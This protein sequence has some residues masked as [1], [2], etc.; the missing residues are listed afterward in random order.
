VAGDDRRH[1]RGG[2]DLS[3]P[4]PFALGVLGL[5]AA[6][7]SAGGVSVL[8]GWATRRRIL[9]VPNERSSHTRPTPRGGG[10]AIVAVVLVGTALCALGGLVGMTRALG[11]CG[12]GAL[13]VAAVSWLEDLR[14]RPVALR[15]SVHV[16]AAVLA[17]IGSFGVTRAVSPIEGVSWGAAIVAAISLVWIVGLTNA[18]NFMDGID[19]IAGT[20]GVIAGIAWSVFGL[21]LGDGG[22]A[23][24]GALMC[25]SCLGFLV[26]NWPPA[27]IFMGDVGSAFLGFVLAVLPLLAARSDARM[28]VAGV[29]VVWPFVFDT[30]FTLCRRLMRRENVFHSHRSHL[31]QRLVVAGWRHRGATL[32]YG[33]LSGATVCVLWLWLAGVPG[34][35]YA[36]VGVPVSGAALVL[37]LVSRAEKHSVATG[38]VRVG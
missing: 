11:L 24:I 12:L 17:L 34:A 9:D 19:G 10:L 7:A 28:V 2:G 16:A 3:F 30:G 23:V 37:W 18:Y 31:Y 15:L 29:L 27:R 14:R 38:S 4:N 13:L 33:A 5:G 8:R 20:Q 26:H 36:V 35:P 32:L 1:A 21:H 22:F 6:L 25:G